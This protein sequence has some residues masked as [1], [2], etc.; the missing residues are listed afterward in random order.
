[1][2]WLVDNM[3]WVMLVSGVLTCTMVFGAI[4]PKAALQSMFGESLDG[5]LAEIIV[6]NWAALIT[7]SG[8]M[9]IYGAYAT[10]VRPFVLIVVGTSKLI[11]ISLVLS[12][13][14]LYGRRQAGIAAAIDMVMVALFAAY[15]AGTL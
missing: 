5:P 7:L 15:L 3:N 14:A 2:A 10:E 4:A 13:F 11:F 8:A 9:L 6:R 1:M 12:Q